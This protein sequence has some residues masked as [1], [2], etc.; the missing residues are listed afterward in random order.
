[1]EKLYKAPNYKHGCATENK[2]TTEYRIWSGMKYRCINTKNP[3]YHKYGGR[4]I[5][6]CDRWLNS[7]EA[8]IEDMGMRP[9]M[10]H[11]LDRINNEGNYEPANCRWATLE[12]Q[13][14]NKRDTLFF[15][16]KKGVTKCLADWCKESVVKYSVV[17][18][19]MVSCNWE[20]DDAISKPNLTKQEIWQ[21]RRANLLRQ[22]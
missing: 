6:C 15:T 11:S 4:G 3:S 2:K 1:M 10:Q 8:F 12:E 17:K 5:M 19:R 21:R 13:A 20:I 22:L 9:T 18:T 16:D 14:N 7:F